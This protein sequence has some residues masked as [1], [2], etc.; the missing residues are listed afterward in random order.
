MHQFK[1]KY[2]N[3]F[4]N[5]CESENEMFLCMLNFFFLCLV[6]F[7]NPQTDVDLNEKHYLP[8]INILC[9]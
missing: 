7:P 8:H 1:D 2:D 6:R 9:G 4:M 3:L 5:I